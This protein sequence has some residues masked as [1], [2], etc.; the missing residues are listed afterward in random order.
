MSQARPFKHQVRTELAS[1]IPE[2]VREDPERLEDWVDRALEIGL[3]SMIQGSGSVDLS[4]VNTAFEGWEADVSNK[5]IG[6]DSEFEKGLEAW[7]TNS[8]GTFQQSFDLENPNSP[9]SKFMEAQKTDRQT[10][11]EAMKTLVEEIKN[12]ISKDTAPKQ[13]K[14]MGDDFEDDI[15]MFLTNIKSA[16]DELFRTG[17][18]ATKG[19][20]GDKKGDLGLLV[21]HPKANDLMITIEAKAGVSP[22]A[23][24]LK[25]EKSLWNQ[26][27]T[28]M[29]TRPAK[30]AIGV[31]NSAILKKGVKQ[32]KHWIENGRYQI[33]VAVDWENMDFT[34]LEIAVSLLR[35]RLIEDM[36]VKDSSTSEPKLDVA[37]FEELIKEISSNKDTLQTMR[38]NLTKIGKI[39]DNQDSQVTAIERAINSQVNQLKMLLESANTEGE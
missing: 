21:G 5:L 8:D 14:Q 20:G 25:G 31:V 2:E 7:L 4:F 35:Y 26:M 15:Q 16:E 30:A 11:E 38:S 3:K 32:H 18:K 29:N 39:I 9:M 6:E 27:T 34:L 10:H 17:E 23:Y 22:G 1:L 12:Q 13:A 33:V 19:S 37:K 28:A 36:A 24:T